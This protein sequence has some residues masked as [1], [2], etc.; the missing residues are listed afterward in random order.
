M[1]VSVRVRTYKEAGI[2]CERVFC[3]MRRNQMH[4]SCKSCKWP[5]RTAGTLRQPHI[6][7]ICSKNAQ[8]NTVTH[9]HTRTQ[10]WFNGMHVEKNK[11]YF[12]QFVHNEFLYSFVD[13]KECNVFILFCVSFDIS[14]VCSVV[15]FSTSF[16]S[17]EYVCTMAH[18]GVWSFYGIFRMGKTK[19]KKKM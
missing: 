18:A 15:R 4:Q 7:A 11:L 16:W 13:F 8:T 2:C 10:N 5:L 19:K 14:V 1:W 6:T 3:E 9:K 12:E 17:I